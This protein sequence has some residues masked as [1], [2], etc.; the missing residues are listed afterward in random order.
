LSAGVPVVPAGGDL[1]ADAGERFS[2]PVGRC[3]AAGCRQP[4]TI[5]KPAA[6]KTVTFEQPDRDIL[7]LL[8]DRV[9][10]FAV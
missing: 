10:Q 7:A 4:R 3:V 2:S 6:N 9:F 5:V 1:N 8:S